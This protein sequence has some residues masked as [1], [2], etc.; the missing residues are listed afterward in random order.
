[1]S[2]SLVYCTWTVCLAETRCLI[3]SCTV[4]GLF[5][6]QRLGVSFTHV[7]YV[8]CLSGR[9]SVT[10]TVCLAETRCLFRSCTVRG[11]FVWQRLG[12]SFTHVHGESMY[13]A[14]AKQLV[15]QL[16]RTGLL[17]RTELVP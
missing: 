14:A 5:V 16:D 11:L 15:D 8:D 12:V 3:R 17:Q 10:W 13:H 4:R 2:R 6:W 9:D 7:L 1:M